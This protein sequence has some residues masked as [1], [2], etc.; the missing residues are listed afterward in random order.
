MM[1]HQISTVEKFRLMM[2]FFSSSSIWWQHFF[3]NY[4]IR[5]FVLIFCRI[6]FHRCSR[7]LTTRSHNTLHKIFFFL[8]WKD[9]LLHTCWKISFHWIWRRDNH[10]CR[11]SLNFRLKR[12]WWNHILSNI[13]WILEISFFHFL[14]MHL[15]F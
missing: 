14:S 10:L 1:Y 4:L 8:F 3:E 15:F 13:R 12:Y 11:F 7:I 6:I 2:R 5:V 9:R